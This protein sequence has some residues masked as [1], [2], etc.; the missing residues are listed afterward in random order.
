MAHNTH[1]TTHNTH[2]QYYGQGVTGLYAAALKGHDRV[3][4]LFLAPKRLGSIKVNLPMGD[5][6]VP[7]YAAAVNGHET[8]V[9]LLL[10]APGIKV[11]QTPIPKPNP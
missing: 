2:T 7:L 9:K 11:H 8:T 10:H 1:N 4:K 3:V 6:L 5:G